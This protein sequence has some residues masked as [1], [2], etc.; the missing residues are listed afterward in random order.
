MTPTSRPTGG[1]GSRR[2][3]SALGTDREAAAPSSMP[4]ACCRASPVRWCADVLAGYARFLGFTT[5]VERARELADLARE[6]PLDDAITRCRVLLAWGQAHSGEKRGWH[7]LAEA[8]DLAV[9]MDAGQELALSHALLG[10]SLELSGRTVEREPTLRAGLRYVAAHG[11]HGGIQ[12]VLEYQLAGLFL[13]LGRWDEADEILTSIRAR[14]VSG[15]A[16]YFT[17]GYAARLAAARGQRTSTP[18][19]SSA[20]SSARRFRSSHCRWGWPCSLRRSRPS[21]PAAPR[22]PTCSASRHGST[23]GRPAL[24]GGGAGR[25]GPGLG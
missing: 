17:A 18:S 1:P 12:A 3:G 15:I 5:D 25:P 21:G 2:T 7:A 16:K 24:E 8:R 10:L 4:S 19:S 23:S 11:L 6:I 14:G 13:E 20:G 9:A 22:L